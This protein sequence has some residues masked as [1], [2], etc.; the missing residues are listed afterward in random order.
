MGHLIRSLSLADMINNEFTINFI[1]QTDNGE[2]QKLIESRGYPVSVIHDSSNIDDFNAVDS[3][4]HGAEIVV[5]DFYKITEDFQQRLIK[6]NLKV[7]CID[8]FH[9]VHFYANIVINVSS[10]ITIADYSCEPYTKLL[11]GTDYAL[12]NSAFLKSALES[13]RSIS[14]ISSIFISMGGADK[15]NNTLKFLKAISVIENIQEIHVM[16]GPINPHSESIRSFLNDNQYLPNVLLHIN[17]NSSKVKSI[18]EKCQLAICPASG[19]SLE[20]CSIGIGIVSGFTADNQLDLLRGLIDKDCAINL[21][22]FNLLSE[23][24]IKRSIE[25][26]LDNNKGFAEMIMNQKKLI[27]GKSPERIK[28]EFRTI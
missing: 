25:K 5:I 27:D 22:D 10:G 6:K 13:R 7:V 26:I 1:I 19:V 9:D 17:V 15:P 23:S 3:F 21:N 28:E 11:L 8:D 12:L 16:L 18:I 2:I 14:K 20:L 4:L 24:E